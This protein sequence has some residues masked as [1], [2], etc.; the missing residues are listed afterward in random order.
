[1]ENLFQY[2][3]YGILI[4]Y[5]F[6]GGKKKKPPVESGD[7]GNSDSKFPREEG[8]FETDTASTGTYGKSSES[9][10]LGEVEKILGL[11]PSR[12]GR[13][14][15]PVEKP[16]AKEPAYRS[17]PLPNVKKQKDFAIRKEVI[18]DPIKRYSHDEKVQSRYEKSFPAFNYDE[19]VTRQEDTTS[20]EFVNTFRNKLKSS[21]NIREM[22]IFAEIITRP[23]YPRPRR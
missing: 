12:T 6:F 8:S 15:D 19:H 1:M 23:K 18:S 4:Y 5:F 22:F 17:T 20:N 10:I 21:S 9:D 16:T 3:I 14:E 2:I 13:A 7:F 11:P